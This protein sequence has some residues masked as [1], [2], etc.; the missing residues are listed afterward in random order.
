[1]QIE[2]LLG[3]LRDGDVDLDGAARKLAE[4]V[5][6]SAAGLHA[7]KQQLQQALTLNQLTPPQ[8]AFLLAALDGLTLVRE[9]TSR[10]AAEPAAAI[11]SGSWVRGRY[12]LTEMIGSGSMGQVWKAKDSY[13]ERTKRSVSLLSR[14]R[15]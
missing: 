8:Y 6:G 12:V 11:E 5:A 14:T 10:R 4:V 7:V 9:A 15:T 1:M 13:L 2:T 3:A